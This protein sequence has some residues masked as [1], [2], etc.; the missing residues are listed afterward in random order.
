MAKAK[1]EQFRHPRDQKM[2][3]GKP[4]QFR[5]QKMVNGKPEQK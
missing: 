2:V 5:D 1:G 4:E 3:N